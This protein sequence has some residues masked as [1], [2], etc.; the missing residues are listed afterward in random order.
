MSAEAKPEPGS[1]RKASLWGWLL[2]EPSPRQ[3][4]LLGLVLAILSCLPVLVAAYPQM[5]DYP[6]H[7]A[8]FH[9]MLN[10]QG[11]LF[12]EGYYGFTW[13][14]SGNLGADL[15]IWPLAAL[16]PLEVA[17]R[18]LVALIPLLIGLGI[19]AT[20]WALRGRIGLGAVL[21]MAFVW[22]P[23]LLLGFLNFGLSL[24][25]ALFAFAG[26]VRLEGKAWRAPLYL[27]VGVLVWL[28]HVSGW[29]VL[30]IMVFGY[31]WSRTRSWRAFVAPWPLLVPLL[32]LL[33]NGPGGELPS[34]G[35]APEVYKRVIWKQAM[36]AGLEW[37]DFASL[38]L[39]GLVLVGSL[40]FKRWDGRLGWAA[41][42]M[43]V[44]SLVMPRHIF[45]GDYVDARMI[46]TGLMTGCLTLAWRAP[47]LVLLI[48]PLLFL[49]R[50]G[51]TTIDWYRDSHET[52][53][54]LAALEQVPRGARV[55]NLVVTERMVWGFNA[56]EHICGYAV[57]KK[58]AFSN[59]N[60]AL[61]DIH[62]LTIK[63][64]GALY[65][66]PYHRM[67]HWPG[68][69][70]DLTGYEPANHAD[71][72]WYV[73]QVAPRQLPPGFVTVAQG[74]RWLLAA[75]RQRLAKPRARS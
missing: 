60:F 58:D 4:L 32:F 20:E 57:V 26:W 35:P 70:I 45:G 18:M 53:R 63:G 48:A 67:L 28:C 49:T 56:Q 69:P 34:Y 29:G 62:M 2:A 10:Q 66:D 40:A 14:W 39:I 47:R 31:E 64:G 12:L 46:S 24:A 51:Y 73:G 37:L 5:V 6:A 11:N 36:R 44:A 42:I 27:V 22:S 15:L 61:P 13:R 1:V 54:L 9:V 65:R 19:V 8:R 23:S 30:G 33:A 25:A 41:M 38:G 59:C 17:G 74:P 52:E 55:A 7:L 68:T 43:V 71:W 75:K 50:L 3:G 16:F 21:A 72:F